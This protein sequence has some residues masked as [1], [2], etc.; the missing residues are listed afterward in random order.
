MTT[1]EHRLFIY[2][3]LL[4]LCTIG[5]A[6]IGAGAAL[7]TFLQVAGVVELICLLGSSRSE[8]SLHS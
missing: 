4:V 1:Q 8:A 2:A 5:G 3:A 7:W 6:F